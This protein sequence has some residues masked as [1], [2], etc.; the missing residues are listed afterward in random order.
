VLGLGRVIALSAVLFGAGLAALALSHTPWLSV[1]VLAVAGFGM[2]AQMASCNTVLQTIVEDD[3]RGRV[4]SLY[5]MAFVGTAP[6]GSLLAGAV[7]HRIGANLT[8]LLGGVVCVLAGTHFA[9]R[10]PLLRRHVR[11]I[12]ERLGILPELAR[13]IQA[14]TQQV[15]PR[16]SD[17]D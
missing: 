9:L 17:A 2:M 4:M 13:G 5:T 12:Y 15:T 16:T 7:A 11:P 6:L 10:L 14:A 8:I 1:S 3:K